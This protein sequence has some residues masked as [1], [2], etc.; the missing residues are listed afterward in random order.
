MARPHKEGMDYFPHD[1]D[2]SSDERIE[3]LRA[4]YGNDGYAFYFIALERIYRT[5]EFELDISDAETRQILAR[6]VG[7]PIDLFE[8]MLATAIKWG[9]FD[10]TAYETKGVLTSHGIK[11]RAAVVI[12]KREKMRARYQENKQVSDA[13][14]R[15]ETPPETPVSDEFHFRAKE[16]KSKEKKSKN[17]EE[18]QTRAREDDQSK[19]EPTEYGKIFD[20]FEKEFGRPLS[21]LEA[22]QIDDFL[23]NHP[24]EIVKEALRQAVLRGALNFRYVIATLNA[25]KN[26]NLRTVV[27]I[28]AYLDRGKEARQSGTARAS[29]NRQTQQNQA[30][31]KPKKYAAGVIYCGDD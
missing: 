17:Q 30:E 25:W 11:K 20:L 10:R 12:E 27:E 31:P 24:P 7:V 18:E 28:R 29:P 22:E 15:E 19:P 9:A 23:K 1:T 21:S 26:Q 8:K 6:K 14:T 16:K 4:L 3:A 13:E 2:A 5:P